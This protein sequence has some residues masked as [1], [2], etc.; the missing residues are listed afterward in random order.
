MLPTDV[1]PIM[2]A[3][4]IYGNGVSRVKEK[5]FENRF[6]YV[7]ELKK[8]GADINIKGGDT[9]VIYGRNK[10]KGCQLKSMDLRGG[11][12][13]VV[14]GLG[15]EGETVILDNG[16]IYRGYEDIIRDLKGLGADIREEEISEEEISE[17]G[18]KEE[19]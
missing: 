3:V 1:Q 5:I 6:A 17:D 19:R 18:E 8:L 12:A 13:L 10:L 14:A 16:Y 11:A 9:L 7:E 15:A 2:A 4:M